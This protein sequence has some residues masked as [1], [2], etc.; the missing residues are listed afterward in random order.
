VILCETVKKHFNRPRLRI[1]ALA[2]FVHPVHHQGRKGTQSK[3]MQETSC[4]N[5]SALNLIEI[6]TFFAALRDV[7][8]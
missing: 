6:L 7:V 1:H 5:M 2:A 8:F 3:T 4:F